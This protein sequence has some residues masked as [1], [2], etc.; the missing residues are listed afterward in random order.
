MIFTREAWICRATSGTPH[1]LFEY[2]ENCGNVR[3]EVRYSRHISSKILS[4]KSD[5]M[6]IDGEHY[7]AIW[8]PADAPDTVEIIDQR[9]LPHE[10]RVERLHTV[11]DVVRAIQDMHV[12]GAPLIGVTAAYGLFLAVAESGESTATSDARIADAARELI[13][14]RPT[15]VN[16]QWAVDKQLTA[17]AKVQSHEVA[18]IVARRVADNI[19]NEDV[20]CCQQ[21]G[22]YGLEI[23][24]KASLVKNG[25]TVNILTHCNAGWL[26]CVDYGTALAPIYS[27]FGRR[28]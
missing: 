13:A 11:S 2:R 24:E 22:R 21:I 26:A 14:T 9:A 23:I 28:N 18:K 19:A 5:S 3:L 25:Q 1:R 15:A 7:R 27:A 4:D 12:R 20:R 6:N 10:F 8:V 16:L 17:L